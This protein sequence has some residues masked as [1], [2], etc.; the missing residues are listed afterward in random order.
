[1]LFHSNFPHVS[2]TLFDNRNQCFIDFENCMYV[3]NF[4]C[5][6]GFVEWLS[7]IKLFHVKEVDLAWKPNI[8]C[9]RPD[10]HVFPKLKYFSSERRTNR[11]NKSI[12][13]KNIMPFVFL[14]CICTLVL[15][16]QGKL[17]NKWQSLQP[18][19]IL[20]DNA[21]WAMSEDITLL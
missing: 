8:Q 3:L 4:F 15:K 2:S 1:M 7:C 19:N 20:T 5:E 13:H 16:L 18:Y 10:I 17:K 12:I 6:L 11:G 9:D 14:T 21:H